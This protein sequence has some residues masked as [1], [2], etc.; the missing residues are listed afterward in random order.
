MKTDANFRQLH[1]NYALTGTYSLCPQSAR[2]ACTW[3][4]SIKGPL[5]LALDSARLSRDTRSNRISR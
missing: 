5:T 4:V 3:R 2:F 1:L